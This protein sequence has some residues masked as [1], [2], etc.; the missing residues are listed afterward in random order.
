MAINLILIIQTLPQVQYNIH[1]HGALLLFANVNTSADKLA[2]PNM[3]IMLFF[4]SNAIQNIIYRYAHMPS[5]TSTWRLRPLKES[6]E[7]SEGSQIIK[8]INILCVYMN[9]P[10]LHKILFIIIFIALLKC[11]TTFAGLPKPFK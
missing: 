2:K 5:L 10:L 3:I 6:F 7:K 1:A 4:L 8:E 11:Y 9:I